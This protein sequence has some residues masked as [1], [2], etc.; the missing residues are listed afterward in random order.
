MAHRDV[1][2]DLPERIAALQRAWTPDRITSLRG[3]LRLR[4]GA[5]AMYIGYGHGNRVSELESGARAV[6]ASVALNL[7]YLDRHGPLDLPAPEDG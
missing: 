1:P 7:E 2:E 5:F 3:R 4:Q 6:T